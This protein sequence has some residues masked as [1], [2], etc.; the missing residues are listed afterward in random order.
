MPFLLVFIV[1]R[2]NLINEQARANTLEAG[3]AQERHFW[4]IQLGPDVSHPS[5]T[6]T[7]KSPINCMKNSFP[8]HSHVFVWALSWVP[9]LARLSKKKNLH[10]R[11]LTSIISGGSSHLAVLICASCLFICVDALFWVQ[12]FW[13][14]YQKKKHFSFPDTIPIR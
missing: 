6:Q 9:A 7:M 12:P 2:L 13:L 10:S 8:A 1:L 5:P 11:P 4:P 3:P 14:G